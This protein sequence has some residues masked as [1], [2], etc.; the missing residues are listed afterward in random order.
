MIAVSHK[1]RATSGKKQHYFHIMR[2][3]NISELE[4][5]FRQ[6]CKG[7]IILPWRYRKRLVTHA[8]FYL[9]EDES[10]LICM[11]GQGFSYLKKWKRHFLGLLAIN[12]TGH[13][14]K[15][16]M[17]LNNINEENIITRRQKALITFFQIFNL[18]FGANVNN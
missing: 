18:N 4:S 6:V 15:K 17:L 13:P 11:R 12:S 9:F 14:F 2:Q 10:R 5:A 1:N 8:L 7:R 3:E 16:S